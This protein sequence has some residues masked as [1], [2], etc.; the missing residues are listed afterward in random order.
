MRRL[1]T[2]GCS[3]WRKWPVSSTISTSEPSARKSSGDP[4]EES[5]MQL[6]SRPCRYSVGFGVGS[7]AALARRPAPAPAAR[8]AHGAVVADGGDDVLGVADGLLDAGDV[9]GAVVAGRPVAPEVV[10]EGVVIEREGN[11]RH[12]GQEEEHVPTLLQLR[13]GEQRHAD[14]RRRGDGGGDGAAPAVGLVGHRAV[15]GQSAQSWPMMTASSPPPRPRA[16]R[17]RP[18]PARRS[19][20]GRRRGWRSGRSHGGT[21]PRRGSPPPPVRAA[22]GA[23]CAPY[24]ETRAGRG[25]A[26]RPRVRRSGRRIRARWR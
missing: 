9:P 11:L 3:T 4:M 21:G 13:V 18:A 10:D 22:G 23:R 14:G 2:S 17:W 16:V 5:G 19:G 1:T 25:R 7:S 6:L 15:G 12:R 26:A 8:G 20:S 24:R